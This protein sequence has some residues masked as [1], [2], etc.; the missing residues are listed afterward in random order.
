[1][2]ETKFTNDHEWAQ[3]EGDVVTVGIT[4]YAQAQLGDIV[5]IELPDIGRTVDLY[6]ESAVVESVKAAGDLKSPISGEI[7]EINDVLNDEPELVNQDPEGEGW[8]YKIRLEE[9]EEFA[10]LQDRA[11]YD[12]FVESLA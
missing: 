2:S 1:M 10:K 6:E 5:Y 11:T 12:A 4:E 3:L 8:F 9:P 7:F